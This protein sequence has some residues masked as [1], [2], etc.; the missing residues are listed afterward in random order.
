VTLAFHLRLAGAGLFLLAAGHLLLPRRFHWREELA[1]LSLLN[2]QVF[3]VHTFFICFV[4]MLMGSLSAFGTTALLQ[5]TPLARW[6]L[7][8]LTLFWSTRLLF[9]WFVFDSRLWR[10]DRFLTFMHGLFT[11]IWIYLTG[12]YGAAWW[13]LQG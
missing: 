9:Q 12:V 8:G 5:P 3:V 4:L 11:L 13:A 7:G 1:Q 2:R 6:V 10:G